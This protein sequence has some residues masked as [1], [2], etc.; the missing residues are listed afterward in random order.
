V[1]ISFVIPLYNCLG[2]TKACLESLQATVP[3]GLE[4]E[5]VFVD[6]GSTDGTREWLTSLKSP[7]R[8]LLN[9]SNLGYAASNNI[10]ARAATGDILGLLNN[11][12]VLMPG[13]LEPMIAALEGDPSIGIVGNVQLRVDNG[14]VDHAGLI[15]TA[16]GKISHDRTRPPQGV[17]LDAACVTAAC[18]LLPR[19]RFIESGGFDEAFVNGGE[20]VD[21]CLRL[22]ASGYRI[23]VATASTVR[24]HVSAARGPTGD[25]DERNSRLLTQRWR[26]EL[27]QWGALTWA[28]EELTA[29]APSLW[30]KS[31]RR[32]L[33]LRSFLRGRRKPPEFARLRIES[34]LHREEIRWR[35]L[36]DLPPG[37]PRAP[38]APGQ[39][40]EQGF[41]RDDIEGAW[42]RDR[43]QFDLPPGFPVANLFIAGF[44]LTA[45]PAIQGHD[46]PLGIRVTLNGEQVAELRGL[47]QRNFNFGIVP[48]LTL[49]DRPTVVEIELLGVHQTNFL[50]WLSRTLAALGV[51]R[52]WRTRLQHYPR[53]G[54]NRRVRF[55]VLVC[56]DEVI[57]DFRQ[58][59]AL[60]ERL[61][62][63]ISKPV[64]R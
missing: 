45:D 44:L 23:V 24:H 17:L 26:K 54:L 56:D 10:G 21:F 33:A 28:K 36:F 47:S 55:A 52:K 2:L 48:P 25:R 39:Y 64:D 16:Q 34:A 43:A 31:G 40:R 51:P 9:E 1:K 8:V 37:T 4:H 42:L 11:D 30:S 15:V 46:R 60:V 5:I 57:F 50:A 38:E 3:R 61:R 62:G 49:P 13:W 18:A 58:E 22:R 32:S 6:D 53:Y 35:H 63:T 27:I 41:L 20:D 29:R 19:K 12:L 59:P 7:A 14:E